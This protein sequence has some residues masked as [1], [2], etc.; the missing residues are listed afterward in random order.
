M[1]HVQRQIR[2]NRKPRSALLAE[3]FGRGAYLFWYYIQ[4]DIYVSSYIIVIISTIIITDIAIIIVVIII[5]IMI[6]TVF[7]SDTTTTETWAKYF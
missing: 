1:E 4:V 5:I 3:V 2:T 6:I 7:V